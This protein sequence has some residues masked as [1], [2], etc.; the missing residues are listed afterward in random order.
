MNM[1]RF[2][3]GITSIRKVFIR[4]TVQAEQFVAKVRDAQIVLTCRGGTGYF[5]QKMMNKELPGRRKKDHR[6]C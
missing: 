3:L 4:G 2:S 5:G 6:E 1:L